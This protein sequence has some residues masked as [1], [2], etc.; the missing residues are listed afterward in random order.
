MMTFWVAVCL[1][2]FGCTCVGSAG[3]FV[4]I[5]RARP[6]IPR[7]DLKIARSPPP[8]SSIKVFLLKYF[9]FSLLARYLCIFI[10]P[11]NLNAGIAARYYHTWF[12]VIFLVKDNRW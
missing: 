5:L 11:Y 1:V 10:W 6:F 8:P 12:N 4:T 7:Q 3:S 2:S 9:F